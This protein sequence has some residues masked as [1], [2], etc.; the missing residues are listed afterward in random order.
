M[1]PFQGI[2]QGQP[3]TAKTGMLV[4][5]AEAGFRVIRCAFEGGEEVFDAYCSAAARARV[6]TLTFEDEWESEEDGLR[7]IPRGMS[8]FESF[9]YNGKVGKAQP[10]GPPRE[11]D[12][13]TVLVF[14]T[15]TS[16]G[17]CAE[18]RALKLNS[19][20]REGRHL[21]AA[22]QDQ[23]SVCQ[24]VMTSKRRHH[25]IVLAHLRLI[26]PKAESGYKDETALQKQVKQER[27]ALEDTGYFPTAV[28]PGI[29]RNFVRHFAFS[30]LAEESDRVKGGSGR[31]LRTRAVPGYQI[32]CPAHVEDRL[33]AETALTTLFRAAGHQFPNGV[34]PVTV[35][36]V[37][38][39]I[40][41]AEGRSA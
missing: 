24:A 14:D 27:A 18:S 7:R 3:G 12:A 38:R 1:T 5:L 28:T 2:I 26:S 15:L 32:K 40:E 34:S 25:T 6:H 10:F 33:P 4:S 35:A 20:T 22:A 13:D 17:E 9:I 36:L 11:W 16:M 39:A 30:L 19:S 29:A 41:V 31:V 21:W 8:A 37:E 23:E